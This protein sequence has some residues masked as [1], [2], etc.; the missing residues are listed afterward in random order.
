MS[1]ADVS[2]TKKQRKFGRASKRKIK[3]WG[4]ESE[5]EEE[6]DLGAIKSRYKP[7]YRRS[8]GPLSRCRDDGNRQAYEAR[9]K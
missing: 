5:E 4:V 1:P 7:D 6:D 8:Q 2:P 9:M 3:E